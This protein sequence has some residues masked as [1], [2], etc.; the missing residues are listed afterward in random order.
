MAYGDFKDLTR[1]IASNK[2]FRD[3]A[4]N[5]VKNPK[6]DYLSKYGYQHGLASMVYKCLIKKL[7]VVVL[8]MRICQTSN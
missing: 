1:G 6:Y 2:I 3:N 8:K 4:F 7:V 5:I